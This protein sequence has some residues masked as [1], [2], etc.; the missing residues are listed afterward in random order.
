[1]VVAFG[2]IEGVEV[3][4]TPPTM[5][6][7]ARAWMDD[8][9]ADLTSGAWAGLPESLAHVL[10]QVRKEAMEECAKVCDEKAA[11]HD[12]SRR[13]SPRLGTA[14]FNRS[15]SMEVGIKHAAEAIRSLSSTI[16]VGK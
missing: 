7:R 11:A 12:A 4:M 14:M 3:A 15:V 10:A 2:Q 6:E 1:M 9:E 16:E 13:T 5:T 8:N